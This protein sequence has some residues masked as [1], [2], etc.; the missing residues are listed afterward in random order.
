MC[1]DLLTLRSDTLDECLLRARQL[2]ET[3]SVLFDERVNNAKIIAALE[4]VDDQLNM[5]A[6]SGTA[7][8]YR[9]NTTATPSVDR[10]P[11]PGKR[12][13]VKLLREYVSIG[14]RCA[15]AA[16]RWQDD[17]R[18]RVEEAVNS[19]MPNDFRTRAIHSRR[20]KNEKK[21]NKDVVS[22]MSS[23]C[24]VKDKYDLMWAQQ[25][26]RRESV[27]DIGNAKGIY[28]F[29]IRHVAGVPKVLLDFAKRKSVG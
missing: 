24:T 14:V 4:C 1:D 29:V 22:A 23:G 12:E 26:E 16:S 19:L 7:S 2:S 20:E 21:F 8:D 28:K 3:L 18:A 17:S 10:M 9:S 6:S 27:A 11:R 25:M 13:M 5:L 15:A